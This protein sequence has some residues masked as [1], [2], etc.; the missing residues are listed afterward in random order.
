[1]FTDK[2]KELLVELA[3]EEISD[4]RSALSNPDG[5]TDKESRWKLLLKLE[6]LSACVAKLK[7]P[8]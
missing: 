1:M 2:E 3:H 4:I 6:M 5:I 7:M 8:T